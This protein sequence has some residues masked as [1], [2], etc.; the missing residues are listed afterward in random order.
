[1]PQK[2]EKQ[3]GKY[4]KSINRGNN[5]PQNESK[6][7]TKSM[8]YCYV[9]STAPTVKQKNFKIVSLLLGVQAIHTLAKWL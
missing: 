3:Q 1:M 5:Y 8:F 6:I 9:W 2:A 4:F 7:K